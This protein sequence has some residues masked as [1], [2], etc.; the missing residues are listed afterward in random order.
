MS[1][2]NIKNLEASQGAYYGVTVLAASQANG[3]VPTWYDQSG[4]ARNAT[5][6][7]AANQYRIVNA[8]AYEGQL[9]AAATTCTMTFEGPTMTQASPFTLNHVLSPLRTLGT[10]NVN[11]LFTVGPAGNVNGRIPIG[12]AIGGAGVVQRNTLVVQPWVG[13]SFDTVNPHVMTFRK[14]TTADMSA[15]NG[16]LNRAAAVSGIA[17]VITAF[18]L[19]TVT[20][21]SNTS[22]DLRE[23]TYFDK[24]LTDAESAPLEQNQGTFYGVPVA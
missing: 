21:G 23:I 11:Y 24:L 9:T 6:T 13:L 20:I 15:V 22:I 7:T 18:S 2:A 16:R 1:V 19:G 4:N 3:F 14:T 8:G 12:A 10:G 5:Q 17:Q